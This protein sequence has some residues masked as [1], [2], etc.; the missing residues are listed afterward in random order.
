MPKN[1]SSKFSTSTAALLTLLLAACG[2]SQS[3]I[4]QVPDG[5]QRVNGRLL[6]LCTPQT[7]VRIQLFG[8]SSQKL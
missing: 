8:D 2:G 7:T 3:L 5:Y 4:D 6:P 1:L